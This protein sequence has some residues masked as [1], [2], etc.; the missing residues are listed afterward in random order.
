M[1]EQIYLKGRTGLNFPATF[2]KITGN[3]AFRCGFGY[4]SAQYIGYAGTSNFTIV[5]DELRNGRPVIFRGGQNEGWWIFGH[6]ANG[7]V[8]VSDG[9][10][11]A[12]YCQIGVSTLYLHMNWGASGF[13]D[14]YYAYNNFNPG[15]ETFNYQSCVIV[16]IKP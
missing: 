5:K 6:Y 13:Y 14:G 2:R 12:Y 3:S 7:H 16:N 10:S 1:S 15:S 11:S 8:W 4:S 9:F